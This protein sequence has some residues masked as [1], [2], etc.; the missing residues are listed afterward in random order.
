MQKHEETPQQK[1][2]V[3]IIWPSLNTTAG[4]QA[5]YLLNYKP[6]IYQQK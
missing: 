3:F 6:I 5:E 2:I 4:K 1:Q